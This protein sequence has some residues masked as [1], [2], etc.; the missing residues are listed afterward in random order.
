M[1]MFI[2]NTVDLL[3]IYHNVGG[4]SHTAVSSHGPYVR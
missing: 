2:K 4:S 1:N 3:T